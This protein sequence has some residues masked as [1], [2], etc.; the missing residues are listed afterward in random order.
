MCGSQPLRQFQMT[1]LLVFTPMKFPLSVNRLTWVTNKMSWKRV[2]A[3]SMARFQRLYSFLLSLSSLSRGEAN[4]HV[5]KTPNQ[6]CGQ[7]HEA[8]NWGHLSTTSSNLLAMQVSH[9][10]NGSSSLVKS[11]DDCGPS[12]QSPKRLQARTTQ[13]SC[14]WKPDPQKLHDIINDYGCFKLLNFEANGY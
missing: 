1:G 13:R 4:C 11:S 7:V 5:V 10:G 14:S 9:L 12:Q 6:L 3:A 8:R 2:S